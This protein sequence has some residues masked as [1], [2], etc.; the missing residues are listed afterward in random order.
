M[1]KF[2]SLSTDSF[3]PISHDNKHLFNTYEL[4]NNFVRTRIS[5]AYKNILAK[6]ILQNYTVDWYSPYNNL[7]ETIDVQTQRKYFAFK[8]ELQNHIN[9]LSQS[10]DAND[11]N[12]AGLLA[13]VFH[14]Q[15][16]KLF[17]NSNDLC[18]VWGWAFKNDQIKRPN[19]IEEEAEITPTAEI[20][21]TDPTPIPQEPITPIAEEPT[22]MEEPLPEEEE[23]IEEEP[24]P[25]EPEPITTPT[26]KKSFLEFLKEFAAI[27]G[28]LLVLLLVLICLTFFYKSLIY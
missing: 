22:P 12:W 2:Y 27:Y 11:R 10:A 20:L 15:D 3:I 18:I 23:I 7:Q 9:S 5:G 21:P 4:V 19:I 14:Q 8:D 16:N 1:K 6:P 24:L 13:K 25:I 17:S 28:W 26:P